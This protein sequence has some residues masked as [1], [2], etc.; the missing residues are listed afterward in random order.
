MKHLLTCIFLKAI[1]DFQCTLARES[2]HAKLHSRREIQDTGGIA[3][4]PSFLAVPAGSNAALQARLGNVEQILVTETKALAAQQQAFATLQQNAQLERLRE[5][6][7]EARQVAEFT[8]HDHGGVRS[9]SFL[10]HSL[11]ETDESNDTL[12]VDS[13][14]RDE[15][16]DDEEVPEKNKIILAILECF[17]LTAILGIDRFYMGEIATGCIKLFT[18]GGCGVWYLVDWVVIVVNCWEKKDSIDTLG[19]RATFTEDSIEPAFWIVSVCVVIAVCCKCLA[20]CLGIFE[21]QEERGR[22]VD[23][24]G[25]GGETDPLKPQQ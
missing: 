25:D 18:L 10:D 11:R 14:E 19:F 20:F 4:D 12:A 2:S 6:E 21:K 8:K 9:A 5:A 15:V 16:R 13:G 22:Q 23:R 24:A 7:L 17:P 1:V 3:A